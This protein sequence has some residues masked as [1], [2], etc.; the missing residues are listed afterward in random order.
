[1]FN[2]NVFFKLFIMPIDFAILFAVVSMWLLHFRCLFSVTPRNTKL[3]TNSILVSLIFI[4]GGIIF[5]CGIWNTIALV[6]CTFSESLF[7][8][9][10]SVIFFNFVFM[11][12]TAVSPSIVPHK[13]VISVSN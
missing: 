1:M 9:S 5:C 3:S 4:F 10:H 11:L 12:V 6:L 2:D 8:P 13:V 7:I